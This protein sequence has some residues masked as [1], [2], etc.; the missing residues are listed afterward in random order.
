L[1]FPRRSA[2]AIIGSMAPAAVAL[3][4]VR[5]NAMAEGEREP[6]QVLTQDDSLSDS[7]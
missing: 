6:A 5:G 2:Q 7:T 3:G 1:G 4:T